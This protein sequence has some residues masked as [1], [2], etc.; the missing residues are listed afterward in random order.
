MRKIKLLF[1][2]LILFF[3]PN[4]SL[5]SLLKIEENP[6][7][8]ANIQVHK[9]PFVLPKI[10]PTMIAKPQLVIER[11]K[12]HSSEINMKELIM[13]EPCRLKQGFAFKENK[14]QDSKITLI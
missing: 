6:D 1:T 4:Q 7:P 10:P 11:E 9:L 14:I 3:K 8:D 13:N 2:L 12:V 5:R